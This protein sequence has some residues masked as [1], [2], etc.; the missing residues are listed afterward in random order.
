M[1]CPYCGSYIK[2]ITGLQ[3]VQNFQKHLRKCKK[4]PDRQTFAYED[5]K[6]KAKNPPTTL[7]N[8]LEI[9]SNSGQ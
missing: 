1:D 4:H 6:L 5:G 7:L 3:E 9:R 2:G 8:A